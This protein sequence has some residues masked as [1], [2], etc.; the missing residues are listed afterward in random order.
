MPA[1]ARH[2]A[3]VSPAAGWWHRPA[4]DRAKSGGA[5]ACC[6]SVK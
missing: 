4:P 2:R 6:R 5:S 3:A 1:E